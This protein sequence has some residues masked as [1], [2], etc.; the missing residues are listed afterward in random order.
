MRLDE[1]LETVAEQIRYTKIRKTVT[2]ELKA[3]ILDQAQSYED[4]GA[5]PEE[6]LERAVR[7]MGDPVE[8][9]VSLDR[10]HRPQMNWGLVILIGILSFFG[11]GIFYLANTAGFD[12][13]FWHNQAVY[14]GIGFLFML[15]IY[16]LDYSLLSKYSWQPCVIYLV[17]LMLGQFF[18]GQTIYGVRRWILLPYMPFAISISESMLLYVPL[19][20]T[21]L[22]AFRGDGYEILW[23]AG[24]LTVIP[25]YFVFQTPDLSAAMILFT[26]LFCLFIFAVWKDWYQISRKLV[27]GISSG[28]VLLIPVIFT[29]YFYFFGE[30]YHAD[31]IRA[32]FS[33]TE[34]GGYIV[35]I[36]KSMR[37][38]SSL[39]GKNHFSVEQLVNGPATD[40]LTDYIVVSMCTL[41]GTLLTIA[42][43]TILVLIIMKIFQISVTQKNQLGMIIGF[44]CGLVFFIKALVSILVNLQFIPHVSINMPFLSYGGSTTIVSYCLLGLV[45]SIYRYKNILPNRNET[46]VRR[47]L[48]LTLTWE[49]K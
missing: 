28:I 40:F 2:D 6:A 30:A 29:G 26:S 34:N 8:T 10:I 15:V 36:A 24:L 33:P 14:T 16:R 42:V 4:C 1:Y 22:Y 25:F 17:L 3:H 44:G 19:F 45:L 23:K 27:A 32:F 21:A 9:G 11:I 47:R 5:F 31:R 35:G 38:S 7:E 39:I 37:E 13:Y 18:F 49:T 41:Y 12:M 46:K 43:I 20:G 48:K